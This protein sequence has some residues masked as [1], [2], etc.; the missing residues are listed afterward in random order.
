MIR[1][2]PGS[3]R[4]DTRFP[5]TTLFRSVG[6]LLVGEE[7]EVVDPVG[8]G[9]GRVDVADA[10]GGQVEIGAP[11]HS[12]GEGLH[13]HRPALALLAAARVQ[14]ERPLDA[15]AGPEGLRV[16]ALGHRHAG[17]G[18]LTGA[19]IEAELAGQLLDRKSTRLNSS[20]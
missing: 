19:G 16:V 7:A 11:G 13:E 6:R 12:S 4:T 1:R 2:P 5:Y 17:P 15:V 10:H 20:H 3:T 8:D 14:Q 9:A 18:Q